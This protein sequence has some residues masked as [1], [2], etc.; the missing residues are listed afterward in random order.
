MAYGARMVCS[1][2]GSGTF[3]SQFEKYGRFGSFGAGSRIRRA[4]PFLCGCPGSRPF[5]AV[6]RGWCQSTPPLGAPQRGR[7]RRAT[8]RPLDRQAK[9]GRRVNGLIA[10]EGV[11]EVLG[12]IGVGCPT[13]VSDAQT[14]PGA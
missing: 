8:S 14:Q 2:S 9:I 6:F 13:R 1:S 7:G 4:T 3:S 5:A 12:R 10:F 11:G